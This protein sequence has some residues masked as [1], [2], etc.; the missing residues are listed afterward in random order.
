MK[1]NFNRI[2]I[3]SEKD[4]IINLFTQFIQCKICMNILN[5]PIDC[6]CCNQT[7][8]RSCIQNY[9]KTNNKCPYQDFFSKNNQKKKS[10]LE[11]LKPSSIN[12]SRFIQSLKF[13]CKNKKNGCNEALSI[14]EISEHDKVCK[15]KKITHINSK[16]TK[17]A[18]IKKQSILIVKIIF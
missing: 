3:P 15:Y 11:N 8:C 16:N 2:I 5:D 12:F 4:K 17:Y 14:E 18:N 10:I 9:I 1:I 13:C 7:F 6:I